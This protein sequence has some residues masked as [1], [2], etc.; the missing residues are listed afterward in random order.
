MKKRKF[1]AALLIVIMASMHWYQVPKAAITNAQA[2]EERYVKTFASCEESSFMRKVQYMTLR[3][4]G[5]TLYVD[6]RT[7]NTYAWYQV[8]LR[9]K[10]Y[11]DDLWK[12]FKGIPK[13]DH[14]F[15]SQIDL[16]QI[17][18]EEGKEYYTLMRFAPTEESGVNKD[19]Y[20]FVVVPLRFVDNEL[21]IVR[22]PLVEQEN[23][24]VRSEAIQDPSYYKD[25]YL[26]D[27]TYELRNG[28][29][30]TS[31][32]KKK[33]T[34][35]EKDYLKQVSD[36]VVGE[37][38]DPAKQ[39]LL[40]HDYLTQNLYYDFPYNRRYKETGL[41][42]PYQVCKS[43][44]E[45][46][47]TAT[48]CNG[49]SVLFAALARAQ[50]IACRTVKGHSLSLPQGSWGTEADVNNGD[51]IWNEV[52]LDG[53]WM[54]LDVQRDCSNTYG[55]TNTSDETQWVYEKPEN[56]VYR[57]S[58]VDIP[59]EALAHYYLYLGY[60]ENP[61]VHIDVP[62]LET[63]KD[64]Y[65]PVTV[66]WSSVEG[67]ESY[68]VYRSTSKEGKYQLQK[69]V[70]KTQYSDSDVT[71][72]KT[73]YYRVS[74]V[75]AGGIE[76]NLS[77][78]K[79]VKVERIAK[80]VISSVK[81]SGKKVA[82]KWKKLKNISTYKVYRATSAKGTYKYIGKKTSSASTITYYDSKS[83][84]S[85]KRYYYKLKAVKNG[86]LGEFSKYKSILYKK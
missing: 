38:K 4:E 11:P 44:E 76:S 27:M 25:V 19:K 45:G 3:I 47:Q 74:A 9:G 29:K 55:K 33:L 58:G 12:T 86:F 64:K 80:P 17:A 14:E 79:S 78:W 30:W 28:A 7:K 13:N 70:K 48:V 10:V 5:N 43:L 39:V 18:F 32:S 52:Y 82:V 22:S 59:D 35:S 1:L 77:S 21:W 81:K 71:V 42:D 73:Y 69:T 36:R 60:R 24:K 8:V 51:H 16:S 37:E 65:I 83:L 49:F 62:V 68:K 40:L 75:D 72:G 67:A 63:I 26:S 61:T 2:A 46:K 57:Y 23:E 6:G 53:R 85:G 20:E 54:V 56:E 15:S 84:K 34:E 50:G 66:K 41:I 31:D